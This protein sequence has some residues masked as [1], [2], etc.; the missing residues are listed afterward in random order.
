MESI[1]FSA[2]AAEALTYRAMGDDSMRKNSRESDK[3][4]VW[5]DRL[6]L[7]LEWII[8]LSALVIGLLI[9]W[10]LPLLGAGW[11]ALAYLLSPLASIPQPLKLVVAIVSIFALL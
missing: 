6:L 10:G 9:I 11:L 2:I 1:E 7:I 3:L 8:S 4:T 5:L